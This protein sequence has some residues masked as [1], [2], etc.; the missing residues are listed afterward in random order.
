LILNEFMAITSRLNG[1]TRARNERRA[2]YRHN[3]R[4]PGEKVA[5]QSLGHSWGQNVSC[6]DVGG[7]LQ[8]ADEGRGKHGQDMGGVQMKAVKV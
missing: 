6:Q 4:S 5:W 2:C 1:L 3:Y 8:R 7:W